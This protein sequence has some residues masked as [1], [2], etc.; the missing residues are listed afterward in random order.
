VDVDALCDGENVVIAG[1]MEHIE[2]AGVHSGDSSCV[3]PPFSL[4]KAGHRDYQDLHSQAGGRTQRHRSGECAV[5]NQR[6]RGVRAR[7]QPP[8]LSNCAVRQQ[9]Y[10]GS[11]AKDCSGLDARARN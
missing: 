6:G 10:R 1:I 3:L 7:G 4:G 2:E 11:A 9:S 5:R 8:S